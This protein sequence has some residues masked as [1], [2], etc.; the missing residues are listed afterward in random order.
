MHYMH[1]IAGVRRITSTLT[2]QL[3]YRPIT[4]PLPWNSLN[5]K[6]I[7]CNYMFMPSY[8]MPLMYHVIACNCLYSLSQVRVCHYYEQLIIASKKNVRDDPFIFIQ[9]SDSFIISRWLVYRL[10]AEF[11]ALRSAVGVRAVAGAGPP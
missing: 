9:R 6:S 3:E 10:A 2:Y 11:L 7:T 8:Y 4:G 1:Y 5:T